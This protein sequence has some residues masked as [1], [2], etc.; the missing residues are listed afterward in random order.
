MSID[1]NIALGYR[2]PQFESPVTQA[3]QAAQLSHAQQ[4]NMLGQMQ[5]AEMGRAAQQ[6]NQMREIL[7]GANAEANMPQINALLE[8]AYIQSGD[9]PS[10]IAHRKAVAEAEAA[11][12]KI[13][14][15]KAKTKQAEAGTATS[16]FDLQKKKY[17]HSINQLSNA[18][19]VDEYIAKV[20]DSKTKGFLTQ[21]QADQALA[22]AQAAKVKDIEEGGAKNY[23]MLRRS[24]MEKLL[25]AKDRLTFE[26]PKPEKVEAG[27]KIEFRDLNPN[28]LTYGQLVGPKTIV[29]TATIGEEESARHN[30][31]SEG[32]QAAELKLK[33]DKALQD[34]DPAFQQSM[35][36]A[37]A[38]GEAIA[39]GDVA[40]IQALPKILD[41]AERSINLIDELVGKQEVR[42]KSGKVIQ[43]GTEPHPGFESAVGAT[44]LPG[45]TYVHGTPAADFKARFEEIKGGGFLEAFE[46]LKGGGAITEKEGE[47][48]TAAITRM[49][50]AQSE[51]EFKSA[52]REFQDVLRTGVKNAQKR[53]QQVPGAT[54]GTASN[55]DA[56]VDKWSK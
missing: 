44:L 50:L 4:Q 19:D 30:K 49:S 36:R 28:S 2:A 24:Y 9:I 22:E 7:S 1:S 25:D 15:S 40:A 45:V 31:R 56:L 21:V 29:K 54:T 51:T 48:A 35:A 42:D 43:K 47:K 3:A 8:K 32:I 16:E 18:H 27:G 20:N 12:A 10:L 33:Q 6:K 53:A 13:Q 26:Q 55:I 14:E 39:K 34:R 23:Q 17:D 11:Q 41:R 52:A 5:M 37:K 46:S 38:T